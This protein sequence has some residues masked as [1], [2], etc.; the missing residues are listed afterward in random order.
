MSFQT[1]PGVIRWKLHLASPPAEVFDALA[2]D[3]GRARFWAEAAAEVGGF[4]TF[5]FVGHP[6]YSGRVIDSEPPRAFA[7]DYFGSP[8]SFRLRSDGAGGTDLELIATGVEESE[9]TETIAGWVSVLMAMKA[10]VDHGI[11]LRNHDP[12]RTW[13]QGYADN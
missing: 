11:D 12:A 13:Q 2:T 8:T 3:A 4:I 7:V 5:H 1:E 9:R 10:A 6:P